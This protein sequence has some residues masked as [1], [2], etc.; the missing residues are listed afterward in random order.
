[1]K[2][3]DAYIVSSVRSAIAKAPRGAL[4]TMRPDDM[5]AEVVKGAIA[6]IPNLDPN[7]IDDLI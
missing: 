6:R 2:S 1:M 5:A 3:Q 4:H 7:Q